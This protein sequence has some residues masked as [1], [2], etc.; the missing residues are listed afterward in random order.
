MQV[1]E[2]KKFSCT[3]L[4]KNANKFWNVTLYDNDDV[5]SE[6]GRQ[7]S[8]QQSKTWYGVGRPFMNKK[9]AEK[10]KKG[11]HENQVVEGVGDIKVSAQKVANN[12]L[13]DIAAKQIKSK[14]TVVS[15]LIDFLV[16]INA[17]Q[18]LKA[19][20][21]KIQYDTSSATFKTT[22]G[23]VIPAQVS[24]ARDL[25]NDLADSIA[26]NRFSGIQFEDDL[27]E[28]LSI[29]PRD[30]GRRRLNPS[31]I[32][33]D[34]SA[35]QKENDIL[36]GLDASFA[37]L[38]TA[39]PKKKTKKKK[40]DTPKIF[41]VQ[42]EIVEDK[43]VINRIHER[44]NKTR[45]KVHSC[46]HLKLKTIYTVSINTME[47]AF[48]NDGK[49]VGNIKS[50]Y[51]GTRSHH[52][53]SILRQGLIIPPS[54]S[55]HVTG[56]LFGRGCYF[57]SSSTK[58]LNYSYGYWDGSHNDRCFLFITDVAMGKFYT[59]TNKWG[60]F[61]KSGYDSTWAKSSIS[62]ILNDEFIVYR[63]SQSNFKYLLEFS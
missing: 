1:I 18:I 21:G 45:K 27:N 15:K 32:L 2:H 41:D 63:P 61:P 51:H 6:W 30:F 14:S 33:P 50:L 40:V 4:G 5:M 16:K 28:Y 22:Q 34:L 20:G 38:Q 29:V 56:S 52:I 19:T 12:D 10:G 43:K 8:T 48:K 57:A 47:E 39:K 11:Y 37:G 44:I 31:D 46:N 17:H 26:K 42:M 36:D 7:G 24:R 54:S 25:L 60:N 49:N 53:L 3:K 59:P 9:I 62:G 23:V 13:K 35:V 58:S 55:A